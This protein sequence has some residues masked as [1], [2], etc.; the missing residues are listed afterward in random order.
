[1]SL[2]GSWRRLRA[3]NSADQLLVIEAAILLPLLRLGTFVLP[4]P[5]LRRF[6]NHYPTHKTAVV[7]GSTARA[8]WAVRAAARR[9]PLKTTCLFEA[10]AADAMLRRRGCTC[11][12]RFGVRLLTQASPFTAHAWIE[13][14]GIVLLGQIENLRDFAPLSLQR[15]DDELNGRLD[16]S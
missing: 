13:H 2:T 1:M 6:L 11:E 9:L 8:D 16:L 15:V 4:F 5:T 12:L 3:L 7:D 14:R 10:L